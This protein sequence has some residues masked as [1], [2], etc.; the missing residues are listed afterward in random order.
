MAARSPAS[1]RASTAA[2]ADTNGSIPRAKNVPTSPAN[3]LPVPLAARAP[4]APGPRAIGLPGAG[5]RRLSP[6]N[7]TT[8]PP[9]SARAGAEGSRRAPTSSGGSPSRR[10]IPASFE[11][12]TVGPERSPNASAEGNAD[13]PPASMTIGTLTEEPTDREKAPSAP[14]G[15]GPSTTAP[16]SG[17]RSAIVRTLSSTWRPS[18]SS[19]PWIRAPGRG[20]CP[21]HDQ[22]GVARRRVTGPGWHQTQHAP[23]DQANEAGLRGAA[24]DADVDHAHLAHAPCARRHVQADLGGVVRG[25]DF[26][27]DSRPLHLAGCRVHPGRHVRGDHRRARGV[28]RRDDPDEGFA[29]DALEARPE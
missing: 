15:P 25:R 23:G 13:S 11:I 20:A 9:R 8:A 14:P 18:S 12:R 7:T 27:A 17:A 6:S 22:D 10:P 1:D 28:D 3:T 19:R 29:D 5:T 4:L 16:A 21:A 24:R 2:A 26:G